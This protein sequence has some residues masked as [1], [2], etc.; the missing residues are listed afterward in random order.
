MCEN[1]MSSTRQHNKQL[2]YGME[3]RRIDV[4]SFRPGFPKLTLIAWYFVDSHDFNLR[5]G[6]D[7]R[8]SASKL[9]GRGS[10]S[11]SGQ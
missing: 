7:G 6:I 1:A 11:G 9:R 10:E 2:S 3:I 8:V 4:G 5:D